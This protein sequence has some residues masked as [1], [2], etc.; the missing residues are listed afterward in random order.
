MKCLL[1]I[2]T[3]FSLF[4]TSVANADWHSGKIDMIAIGY[5][6]KTIQIG[7]AGSTKTDCTCYSAWAS[8]YCLDPSRDTYKEEY[9]LALSAK[10]RDKSVNINIDEVTCKI[11]AIY[12][13]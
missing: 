6:G 1:L 2:F 8:R 3:I 7:Q 10:A 5:D 9:A 11:K 4:N 12:E 13:K